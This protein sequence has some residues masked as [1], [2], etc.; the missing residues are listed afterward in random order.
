MLPIKKKKTTLFSSDTAEAG[1][2]SAEEKALKAG[3][4]P[5]QLP[6]KHIYMPRK[7]I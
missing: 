6:K 7:D 2:D 1:K 3:K 5:L 4:V